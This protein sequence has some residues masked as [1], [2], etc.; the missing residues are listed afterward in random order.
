MYTEESEHQQP[1]DGKKSTITYYYHYLSPKNLC[2]QLYIAKRQ[3]MIFF[4]LK[5]IILVRM[6]TRF[7]KNPIF[8]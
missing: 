6:E 3:S 7:G 4:F 2:K 5:Q 8:C 1:N